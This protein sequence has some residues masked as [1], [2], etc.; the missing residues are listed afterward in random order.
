LKK[1]IKRILSKIFTRSAKLKV[2][3]FGDG[4]KVNFSCKFT[5]KTI[6]GKNCHFNGMVVSG[7]GK[8]SIGN[9]FHSGK[10]CMIIS[11]YHNYDNGTRIPYD[12]TYIDKDVA[13]E[14]NVWLGSRVIILGGVTIGEGAVIQAGS[15]VT[16]DI[17]KFG[18]AGGHPAKVFKYR[19]IEH[20]IALKD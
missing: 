10:E 17:P 3:S 16:C 7:N 20:Y 12:D 19:D 13:I 9:N 5:T 2:A 15:V 11:S 6:I 8:V 4:S 18:V 14:A 1:F